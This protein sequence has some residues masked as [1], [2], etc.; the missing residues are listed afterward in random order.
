MI[1]FFLYGPNLDD[2]MTR[3][4]SVITKVKLWIDTNKLS[5]NVNKT[6]YMIFTKREVIR[7][8]KFISFN[9][10]NIKRVNKTKFLGFTIQENLKWSSHVNDVLGK[11]SRGIAM[12]RKVRQILNKDALLSIYYSFIYPYI[13]RGIT[14]WANESKGNMMDILV[15]QKQAI[16]II[17]LYKQHCALYKQHLII[18]MYNV[19]H[20]RCPN[21]ISDLFKLNREIN[22]N[23]RTRQADDFFISPAKLKTTIDS[24]IIQA[25][26]L[27]NT[28]KKKL[29]FH[30]S[31][32]TLKRNLKTIFLST[33]NK[34][35]DR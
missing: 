4:K 30:F 6:N 13:Q 28:Y 26:K 35:Q 14:I 10:T 29:N 7:N 17:V 16:R 19:Y 34:N 25:P 12:L 21:H 18:L 1:V 15:K 27:Y 11:M 20:Q 33:Y 32:G 23:A 24:P 22:V 2:L 3:T 31:L 9:E 5:L 8:Y